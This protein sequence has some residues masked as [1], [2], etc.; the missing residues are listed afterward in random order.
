MSHK[1]SYDSNIIDSVI[2]GFSLNEVRSNIFKILLVGNS[3][4]FPGC[5]GQNINKIDGKWVKFNVF[6]VNWSVWGYYFFLGGRWTSLL[7]D[8]IPCNC[9]CNIFL[10][11]SSMIVTKNKIVYTLCGYKLVYVK[12]NYIFIFIA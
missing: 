11:E 10:R 12:P 7:G 2:D 3:C 5:P 4:Y 1:V 6:L 8:L 9:G